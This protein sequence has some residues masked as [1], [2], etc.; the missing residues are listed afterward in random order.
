MMKRILYVFVAI[1]LM[2]SLSL[3][4][5][6]ATSAAP[7]LLADPVTFTI[8]HTNDFHG[9]LELS[10]SNPG[11]ARDAQKIVDI[12]TAI[13]A[14]NVLLMD[15]GDIMQSTLLSNLQKGLPTIDYFKQIGYD[16][17]TMG[18]HEFD[19]G[20]SV[21]AK[22][23]LQ[24]ANSALPG[25]TF[26]MVAANIVAKVGGSCD[27]WDRP[28]LTDTDT[29]QTYTIQP[30]T[31]LDVAG[32]AVQVGVIGVGSVETPYITIA[33]ATEGLCFKDPAA[34]IIHYYDEVVAAGAD[35]LVVLSH[36]GW[37]DGGYGYGFTVYGDQT[38]AGM[39]NTAGKP[40]NLIIGGHS[41]TSMA[42]ATVKG[43]TTIVQAAYNGRRVGRADVTVQPSGAVSINWTYTL[44]PTGATAAVDPIVDG[45]IT[46]YASDPA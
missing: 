22:R 12:R 43:S 30:Y 44:V 2:L 9:N 15:A 17:T 41:H 27:G 20:Q 38:L 31:I 11:A 33:E 23:A 46:T 26:P 28:V 36:N 13:G 40:V 16:V 10:G 21:L 5:T 45:L 35:V 14:D 32:G 25:S 37:T 18:N 8:L 42:S 19:W 1:A 3:P 6:T 39:L 34:S 7:S 24:A 4:A 29:S